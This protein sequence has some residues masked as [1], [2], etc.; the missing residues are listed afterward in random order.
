M[1]RMQG[2]PPNSCCQSPERGHTASR[3]HATNDRLAGAA[4][5]LTNG[6][7]GSSPRHHCRVGLHSSHT[8][9]TFETTPPRRNPKLLPDRQ[10]LRPCSVANHALQ[11]T[12]SAV[13]APAVLHR[14]LSTHRQVPRPLR[15]SLSLRSFA[16]E[17]ESIA[18]KLYDYVGPA[19]IRAAAN[20][21]AP[22]HAVTDSAGI[23]AWASASL[24][25]STRDRQMT[26]TYVVQPPTQ[27]YLA[28]RRS[29]HV[30]CARGLPVLAAGEITFER[31]GPRLSLVET[32]NLSTGFCPESTSWPCLSAALVEA[33]F[34][35]IVAY[36][37][38]F[39]F[40]FCESCQQTCVIKDDFF[41]CPSCFGSLPRDWNYQQP[42]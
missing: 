20:F 16:Q 1:M 32:S 13:T 22:R 39:E 29:E 14:R 33:G 18:M 36:T 10:S 15:L 35:A 27:L 37:C 21:D 40:R 30:V 23:L 34:P 25:L 28:D 4:T 12:G 3:R 6:V 42:R 41:E 11:R 24:D 19:S 31:D 5:T 7:R 9:L 38:P 17:K 8:H 2:Q 26:F